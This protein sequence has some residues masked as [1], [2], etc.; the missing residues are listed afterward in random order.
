MKV[1]RLS[2][3]SRF[4]SLREARTPFDVASGALSGAWLPRARTRDR[5][6]ALLL[7]GFGSGPAAMFALKRTVENAGFDTSDWG[8]G[9]NGGDVPTLLA[10]FSRR[11]A[12]SFE[13]SGRPVT[14]V[15]WSLGGSIAREAAR[16]LPAAVAKVITLGTPVFGGPRYTATADFYERQGIDVR[17]I[18]Q[19][20]IERFDKPL[21][22]PVVALYSRNDGVVSWEACIDRWSPDVEHI[23]V[24]ASHL[25][26]GF[27]RESL[28]IVANK[29]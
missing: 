21:N 29:I 4:A 2:A 11:V 23:E 17:E 25:G 19:A 20:T 14:L 1:P 7:P 28:K 8:L 3:P 16:D 15:G 22:V 24:K 5:G 18:E 13:R 12:E 10:A 6:E 9:F 27:A 26:M